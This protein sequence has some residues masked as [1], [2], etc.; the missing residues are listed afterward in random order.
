MLKVV[1]YYNYR[2]LVCP[3]K[4]VAIIIIAVFPAVIFSTHIILMNIVQVLMHAAV[5]NVSGLSMLV[6]H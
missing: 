3:M 2:L 4:Y 1:S 5:K 6:I